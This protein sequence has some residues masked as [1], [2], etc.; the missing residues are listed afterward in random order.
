MNLE[1]LERD[2]WTAADNLRANSKL[3]AAQ[4]AMPVL[5]LIFLRHAYNRFL[6][7]RKEIEPG[8]PRRNGKPRDLVPGD[9]IGKAALYLPPSAWYAHL[10]AQPEGPELP[11]AVVTAMEQIEAHNPTLAGILPKAYRGFEPRLLADLIKTFNSDHLKTATGDVFGKIYEYFLNKFAQTGAQEGGEFFTPPSLVRLIVNV[12]EPDHGLVFD[13]ACGSGGMFVQTGHFIELQ[14]H[15]KPHQRVVFHG[16]EKAETNA[17]LARMNLAVHGLEGDIRIANSFY[18][19]QPELINRCDFVMANPPFNVD[20]VN[21]NEVKT[22]VGQW[23]DD[24]E[25]AGTPQTPEAGKRLPFGLPGTN[26]KTKAISNAN[27]LWVQYFYAYLNATGRAGFVMASSASDAGNKDRDIRRRLVGTGHVDAMVAIGPKFFYTRSLPCTLWF[28]D[29]GK[30]AHAVAPACNSHDRVLMI[31]ARNVYHVES[32]RHHRFTDAQLA[33][34]TAIVWLH[35][36]EDHKF[37]DLV[38]RYQSAA[39]KHLGELDSRFTDR[40]TALYAALTLAESFASTATLDELNRKRKDDDDQAPVTADQL[41]EFASQIRQAIT[42]A[43]DHDDELAA[44]L[45][46][47]E[48]ERA[49]ADR[50]HDAL[51]LTEQSAGQ[52]RLEALTDK[53][54]A[55]IKAIEAD[56]KTCGRLLEQAEKTL[57]ARQSAA[58]DGKQARELRRALAPA[59]DIWLKTHDDQPTPHDAALA[60]LKAAL[61]FI[62]QGHWLLHRFP[63]A[64][65]A[66]VAGLCKSVTRAEVA[67]ADWSLTPGR[68]VGVSTDI[69]T[70]DETG[71]ERLKE[72]AAELFELEQRSKKLSAA[73]LSML[74]AAL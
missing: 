33:N 65:Y 14:R 56:H 20:G 22:Q 12:I 29:K 41:S 60:S 36:G 68:Y 55:A 19:E 37:R 10:L 43:K 1:K 31:D 5:G 9:F 27:S 8:L 57:R 16:Q 74:E 47:A 4:Y 71:S 73:V 66:D 35:R 46:A 49:T 26:A 30:P 28:F 21:T 59:D 72:I 52:Q 50:P 45:A 18:D 58:W 38:A 61:H 15:A 23:D 34:L 2:L 63:E 17:H 40:H 53:L 3:T 6:A 7:V 24:A 62:A 32:A 25:A 11:E 70:R 67:K 69:A 51:A 64:R 44:L 48:S 13:P 39:R 54:R 42:A